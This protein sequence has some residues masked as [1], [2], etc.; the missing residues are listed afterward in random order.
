M[1]TSAQFFRV[2]ADGNNSYYIAVF[3]S[4]QSNCTFFSS[5]FD[6]H[7]F[8]I[9]IQEETNLFVNDLFNF[10]NLFSCHCFKVA[11]VESQRVSCYAGTCLRYVITQN[12]LQCFVQQMSCC[13]VSCCSISC[14]LVDT[15]S[16]FIT[17]VQFAF[18]HSDL[19][20]EY[21]L[22]LLN[23]CNFCLAVVVV[24]STD[25]ECLSAGFS[26]E[27]SLVKYNSADFTGTDACQRLFVPEHSFDFA[28]THNF[29]VTD[30]FCFAF[31]YEI[32]CSFIPA[33]IIFAFLSCSCFFFLFF[34]VSL[35]AFDINF[36]AL[37]FQDFF[38]QFQRESVC[39]M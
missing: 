17:N 31:E 32:S 36:E 7:F 23:F 22:E 9:Y 5:I 27:W 4:E 2:I 21:T 8:C 38:C 10:C 39:V 33:G 35:E 3:F 25:I 14:W 16:Y 18:N 24:D 1:S 26:I 15:Q 28:F 11:E 29:C 37:F 30:E 19:V 20:S 12:F 34:H 13:V 6:G